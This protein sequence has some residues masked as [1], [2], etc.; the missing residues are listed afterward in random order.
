MAN[1]ENLTIPPLKR[2]ETASSFGDPNAEAQENYQIYSPYQQNDDIYNM[3]NMRSYKL[4]PVING[5][6]E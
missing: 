5:V 6:F 3:Y 2:A 1:S 4:L